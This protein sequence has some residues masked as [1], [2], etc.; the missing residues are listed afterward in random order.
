[1][2]GTIFPE[3]DDHNAVGARDIADKLLASYASALLYW[4][5][6]AHHG[7]RIEVETPDESI[8]AH[9]LHLLHGKAPSA[10][11]TE[12]M[13]ISLNL[14]AEHEFIES[15]LTGRD[16]EV[17]ESDIYSSVTGSIGA[18]SGHKHCGANEVASEIQSRYASADEA[19][20][21]IKERL[22]RKEV[23]IG[24]GHPVYTI[25]DP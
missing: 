13:A 5:H 16:I 8:G 20:E 12:A 19:D 4:Y 9:F 10:S 1:L 18:L 17:K 22:A 14:Y 23:I 3:R 25:S 24:F 2:L 11:W 15:T 7:K 21:D 6:Y